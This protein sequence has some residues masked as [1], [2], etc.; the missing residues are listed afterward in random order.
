MNNVDEK[1][2]G[3]TDSKMSASR[4]IVATDIF[5]NTLQEHYSMERTER[6]LRTCIH[7]HKKAILAS[8]EKRR[9]AQQAQWSRCLRGRTLRLNLHIRATSRPTQ[10]PAAPIVETPSG[11]GQQ[12]LTRWFG[13]ADRPSK[14]PAS[15]SDDSS[16]LLTSEDSH[17]SSSDNSMIIGLSSDSST[18]EQSNPDSEDSSP[19]DLL[20]YSSEEDDSSQLDYYSDHTS[21]HLDLP[22]RPLS[23]ALQRKYLAMT[24]THRRTVTSRGRRRRAIR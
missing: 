6:Q 17:S 2:N 3:S 10:T 16:Y 18:S 21:S 13:P 9:Q 23:V 22:Q 8:V 14:K 1:Q 20:D 12:P 19:D 4:P 5:H 11:P 7:C 24:K 15:D